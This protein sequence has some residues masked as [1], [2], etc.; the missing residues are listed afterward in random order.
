MA[1]R[2]PGPNHMH[3]VQN[4]ERCGEATSSSLAVPLVNVRSATRLR[5]CLPP[6]V[7]VRQREPL[8]HGCLEAGVSGKVS[9][10]TDMR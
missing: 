10:E 3:E 9:D 6:Q 8:C 5:R 1:Q 7:L 4:R 2:D